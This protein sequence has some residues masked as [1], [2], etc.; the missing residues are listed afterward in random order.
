M[1]A[2][3]VPAK[4]DARTRAYFLLKCHGQKLCKL[5]NPKCGE[6]PVAKSCA[7]FGGKMRGRAARS[8]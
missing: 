3:D 4:F 8:R 1:I 7:F 6:C 2:A 5:K